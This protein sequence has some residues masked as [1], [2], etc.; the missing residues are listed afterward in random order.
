M[1]CFEGDVRVMRTLGTLALLATGAACAGDDGTVDVA[2]GDEV[3]TV[4]Q[5]LMNPPIVRSS[6]SIDVPTY[7]VGAYLFDGS[8]QYWAVYTKSP[9]SASELVGFP[10]WRGDYLEVDL[11]PSGALSDN[12][13]SLSGLPRFYA[14]SGHAWID[15][16]KNGTFEASEKL[17]PTSNSLGF[18]T[19]HGTYLNDFRTCINSAN[20]KWT[21]DAPGSSPATAS[22][23]SA[24][25]FVLSCP[26]AGALQT[27]LR[28]MFAK[29]AAY[30]SGLPQFGDY[31][32]PGYPFSAASSAVT[33]ASP[34]WAYY[35]FDFSF[36]Q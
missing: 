2:R 17:Q 6:T 32:A 3:A 28:V 26:G 16:N 13:Y 22:K 29:N 11:L 20:T 4:S 12:Q 5:A 1:K 30:Y 36:Q 31:P 14:E 34:V 19:N 9:A 10:F 23:G 33:S 27:K 35:D 21:C 18:S 24:S 8:W 7:R 15:C 25:R